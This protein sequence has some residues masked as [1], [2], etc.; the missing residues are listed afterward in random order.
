MDK[1][2]SDQAHPM[3]G[4]FLI[5]KGKEYDPEYVVCFVELCHRHNTGH[6]YINPATRRPFEKQEIY[7][8]F[9]KIVSIKGGGPVSYSEAF[10]L[11]GKKAAALEEK[12]RLNFQVANN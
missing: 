4:K 11:Y 10:Y 1:R 6:P 9:Q 8:L 2:I 5:E 3:N 12:M 7:E